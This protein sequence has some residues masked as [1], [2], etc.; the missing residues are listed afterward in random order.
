MPYADPEQKKAFMRRYY[1]TIKD[2]PDYRQ[3]CKR[4]AIKYRLKHRQK[5]CGLNIEWKTRN[6]DKVK[7]YRQR[8]SK[9]VRIR[10]IGLLG[11][12][13]SKCGISDIRVLQVDHIN[14]D[15]AI[16]RR[17][18]KQSSLKSKILR[19]LKIDLIEA[20]TRY[21]LLC[22][23]CNWIK[24]WEKKECQRIKTNQ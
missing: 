23:N 20:K 6:P 13:C 16:E 18:Y 12:R 11:G 5:L 1:Q 9:N 10:I 4:N 19:D 8:A 3:R 2:D 7:I 24:V 15:G 21:Q 22:A 17:K 14:S